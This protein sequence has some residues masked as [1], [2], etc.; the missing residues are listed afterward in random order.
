MLK[1]VVVPAL[2]AIV[3]AGVTALLITSRDAQADGDATTDGVPRVIAYSGSLQQDGMDVTD[4]LRMRFS[5]YDTDTGA[6][7]FEQ[8]QSVEVYGGVFSVLI[9]PTADNA[10]LLEDV[11]DNAEHSNSGS[12]FSVP[13]TETT[14]TTSSSSTARR[15]SRPPTRSGQPSPRISRSMAR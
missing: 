3:C 9:G 1:N 5:L 11:V 10:T 4:V 7:V 12:R 13:T 15:S 8:T 14:Q 2:V 6:A